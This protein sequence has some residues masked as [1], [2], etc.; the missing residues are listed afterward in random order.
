MATEETPLAV[1]C[2]T[3]YPDVLV[4]V[5]KVTFGEKS[6][7]KMPDCNLRRKQVGNISRAACALLNSGGGVIKAE[8]DNKDYSYEEHGIGQDIEKALTELTPSKMSRKYFDFE[9]MRV[10]N[11]V[12]IFVKS[13]SRDGSS[14]PRICSLR[15][16]LYQRCLT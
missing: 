7:K 9:Y 5:G 12:L 1:D 2:F 10:N 8:V 3:D 15:T 4:N 16:G 11:C 13:W 6:R 14:L